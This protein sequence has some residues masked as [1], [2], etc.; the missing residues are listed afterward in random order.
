MKK[1]ILLLLIVSCA[2]KPYL[3]SSTPPDWMASMPDYCLDDFL[4]GVGEGRSMTQADDRSKGEILKTIK[5][6]IDSIV[7][8]SEKSDGKDLQSNAMTETSLH[9]SGE[10]RSV[11]VVQRWK[12]EEGNYFTF[13]RVKKSV[14][15][16]E[17]ESELNP[18]LSDQKL[19]FR[20][21]NL[22]ALLRAKKMES[23]IAPLV[24]E[25][26]AINGE[27]LARNPSVDQILRRINNIRRRPVHLV[28]NINSSS[29]SGLLKTIIRSVFVKNG[30]SLSSS[31]N[32]KVAIDG[33]FKVLDHQSKIKGFIQKKAELNLV[34]RSGQNESALQFSRVVSGR[35]I[36][37]VNE[38]IKFEIK[39][40][41]EDNM[42]DL[43]NL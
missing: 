31:S 33:T 32:K 14:L 12:K 39:R 8:Y 43:L 36:S 41:L 30:I 17:I 40:F 25:Y 42:S 37:Q 1:I 20:K 18:L 6:N 26:E 19:Q 29:S 2:S 21:N 15:L 24:F 28:M 38:R 7:E 23:K 16:T 27:K 4:C 13:S 5:S 34:S 9:S 3:E 11:E 10:L 22:G 35:S